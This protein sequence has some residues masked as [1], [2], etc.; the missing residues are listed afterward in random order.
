VKSFALL[1]PVVFAAA[2]LP[3]H[4]DIFAMSGTNYDVAHITGSG[5][6]KALLEVDFGTNAAPQA[7]LFGYEW[8]GPAITGRTLLQA[9]QADQIGLSFTDTYFASF[10]SYLLNTLWYQANQPPD[11]YPNSF[12][13]AFT[14]PDGIAWTDT[15]TGYDQTPVANGSYFGWALQHDDPNFGRDLNLPA[16]PPSHFPAAI[17]VPEPVS[18][19]FLGVGIAALALRRSRPGS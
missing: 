12:W 9:I 7:Y 1:I 14:S 8:N 2:P 3:L 19:A 13:F 10:D 17:V 15:S 5:T 16:L 11:D 4:A 18:L 6:N